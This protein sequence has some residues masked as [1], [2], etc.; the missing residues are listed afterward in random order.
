MN[1]RRR[2]EITV[3]V[4]AA[5]MTVPAAYAVQRLLDV[6]LHAQ[7]NPAT[8][9]STTTIAMF[10]RTAFGAYVAPVV[11]FGAYELARRDIGRAVEAIY[12]A[13]YLVAVLVTAQAIVVPLRRSSFFLPSAVLAETSVFPLRSS[14]TCT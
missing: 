11:G 7:P 8:I 6:A 3:A 10:T 12:T 13:A 4:I 1:V 9:I 5:V 2:A 14:I